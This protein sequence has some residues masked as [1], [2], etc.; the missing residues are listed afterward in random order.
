[1]V[2][3]VNKGDKPVNKGDKPVNNVWL[4]QLIMYG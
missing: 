2:K 1:M 3:P 4:N